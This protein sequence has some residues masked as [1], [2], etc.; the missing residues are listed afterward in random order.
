MTVSLMW[1]KQYTW[2]RKGVQESA[3]LGVT[4]CPLG[5]THSGTY[6]GRRTQ[7]LPRC[8]YHSRSP[9]V[10]QKLRNRFNTLLILMLRTCRRLHATLCSMQEWFDC[11]RLNVTRYRLANLFILLAN[12]TVSP[13]TFLRQL[14][15]LNSLQLYII[16]VTSC[17][18]GCTG[19]CSILRCFKCNS[20]L[21]TI[22][23]GHRTQSMHGCL[24]HLGVRDA[25]FGRRPR[26]HASMLQMQWRGQLQVS[27]S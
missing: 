1:R 22:S 9:C 18:A 6:S 5:V 16:N 12:S 21:Y 24:S 27:T 11:V 25:L 13:C 14:M 23:L 4:H 7:G 20:A 10:Q 8:R 19:D 26:R 3:P 2:S 15:N 17:D